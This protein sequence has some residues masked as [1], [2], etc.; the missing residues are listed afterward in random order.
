MVKFSDHRHFDIGDLI[1][2]TGH[3]ISGGHVVKGLGI[4]LAMS[5]IPWSMASGDMTYLIY[6][7]TS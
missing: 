4:R 3:L 6:H 1:N 5:S 7:V 2:L